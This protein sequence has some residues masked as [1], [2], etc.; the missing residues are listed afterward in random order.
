MK[1]PIRP[2]VEALEPYVPGEQP[3]D[4]S[5]IKLNTNEN[6]YPPAS[7]VGQALADFQ[8]STLRLYPDPV[9]QALRE[10]AARLHGVTPDQVIFGN[11][12]DEIIALCTRAFVPD[13]HRIGFFDPSYSLYPVLSKIS[14]HAILATPLASDFTCGPPNVE[15]VSLFFWTNPNAPTGIAAPVEQIRTFA[16]SFGGVVVVDEAYVDFAD[17]SCETILADCPN[18]LIT[19]TFSKS[20]ALAWIRLGYAFGSRALIQ[21][22]YKIK[23]SYN[24]NGLTQA[25]G[26][27]ALRGIDE[28]RNT[29]GRIVSTRRDLAQSL[30]TKGF[31]VLPSQTNFLF[32]RPPQGDGVGLYE[33]LKAHKIFVRYFPGQVTGAFLR[34]TIGTEEQT[35]RFL[36]VVDAYLA[37]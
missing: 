11:G 33:F 27:A 31:F 35:A 22:L 18:L 6:P 29:A 19:R 10:E 26:L 28:M 24:V 34:I 9:C 7:T 16:Q 13:G 32:V 20:H 30:T 12:S 23:D 3:R 14:D 21:A 1:L 25:L 36:S 2:N 37:R 15:G 5:I 4:A 17:A 8:A